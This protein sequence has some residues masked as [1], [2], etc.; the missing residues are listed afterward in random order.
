[1]SDL[2]PSD[3]VA[4]YHSHAVFYRP[5]V[6]ASPWVQN[7][8]LAARTLHW[9]YPWA[10]KAYPGLKRGSL[11]LFGNRITWQC[12]AYWR[13]GKRKFPAWAAEMAL[14]NLRARV[15]VAQSLIVELE[16]HIESRNAEV[17]VNH[18]FCA[19]QSDG[20]DRRGAKRK[21]G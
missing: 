2:E 12:V 11:A 21:T 15:S 3:V 13:N 1:M 18:G 10:W 7:T 8:T 20:K 5:S 14:D 19:V 9:L 17:R 16:Q 4:G 6:V